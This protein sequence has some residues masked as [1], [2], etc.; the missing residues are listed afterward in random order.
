MRMIFLDNFYP[1]GHL[2]DIVSVV[3]PGGCAGGLADGEV[4][5]GGAA[6]VGDGGRVLRGAGA[7]HPHLDRGCDSARMEDM[8]RSLM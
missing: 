6:S 4:V 3:A 8:I 7:L 2:E 5:G 1:L